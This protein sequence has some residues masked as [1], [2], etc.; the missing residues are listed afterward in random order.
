MNNLPPLLKLTKAYEQES[1]SSFIYRS[2]VTIGYDEPWI[3][4][5]I[6]PDRPRIVW[7]DWLNRIGDP[8]AI[9]RIAELT[10]LKHED[11]IRMTIH[12]F[13]PAISNGQ[14]FCLPNIKAPMNATGKY[15]P[16]CVFEKP[17]QQ[18]QWEL[19]YVTTCLE[20]GCV[21]E[22]TCRLCGR[23]LNG[24]LVVRGR[25]TCGANLADQ[26]ATNASEQIQYQ[27][28]IYDKLGLR[29]GGANAGINSS[30]AFSLP[31]QD[32]FLLLDTMASNVKYIPG[33]IDK[34]SH[35]SPNRYNHMLN[36]EALGVLDNW[37]QNFVEF[38]ESYRLI[39]KG[40]NLKTG[41]ERDF[42]PLLRAMRRR[43]SGKSFEFLIDAMEEYLASEWTGGVLT[44]KIKKFPKISE[45]ID[46][47][48]YITLSQAE[49]L[50]NTKKDTLI[51][52]IKSSKLTAIVKIIGSNYTQYLIERQSV[53]Q[54]KSQWQSLLGDKEVAEILKIGKRMVVK[55]ARE[56]ILR[57]ARGKTV[58]G[59]PI[60]LFEEEHIKRFVSK[61]QCLDAF[62]RGSSSDDFL[63]FHDAIKYLSFCKIDM[64]RLIRL[65]DEGRLMPVLDLGR[66]GLAAM[67]FKKSDL[68]KL[69]ETYIEKRRNEYG[70]TI[71]E[72]AKFLEV[73]DVVVKRWVNRGLLR[74]SSSSKATYISQAD[75]YKFKEEYLFTEAVAEELGVT[76][77]TVANWSRQGKIKACSGPRIDGGGRLIFRAD[78][79]QAFTRS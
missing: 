71:Q 32:F 13:A 4:Q 62:E 36:Q 56:G 23:K 65:V 37:P 28:I 30:P 24:N 5:M 64:P 17:H 77:R 38:L 79:V 21:L 26:I 60:W 15:C 68:E 41:I 29:E 76:P 25:C 44:T 22:D 51:A 61:Y 18:V 11:I 48:R 66:S 7:G 19:P 55:L 27:E 33:F 67:M 52:L 8:A 70:M 75:I 50:L 74:A 72:A 31:S 20:H 12:Y 58:D 10:L 73:K 1:L 53:E 40:G 43:L 9:D 63:A 69:A 49:K 34:A 16:S 2:G 6:F 35:R 78:E 14:R 39:P 3:P 57:P 54:L 42:A 46:D 47:Q 59:H 45:R